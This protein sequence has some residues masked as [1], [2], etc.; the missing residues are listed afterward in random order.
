V[1]HFIF[2]YFVFKIGNVTSHHLINWCFLEINFLYIDISLTFLRKIVLLCRVVFSRVGLLLYRGLVLG[3]LGV[4]TTDRSNA[5]S[6]AHDFGIDKLSIS[7]REKRES[8][9]C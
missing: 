9:Y 5:F 1:S 3:I 6:E 7:S 4:S 2:C 8:G